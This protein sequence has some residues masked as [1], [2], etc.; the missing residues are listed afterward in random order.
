MEVQP[1]NWLFLSSLEAQYP[2]SAL[3]LL[4]EYRK[5]QKVYEDI[6]FPF[7][8][9]DSLLTIG[10]KAH[11]ES[12]FPDIIN[13][14]SKSQADAGLP[15]SAVVIRKEIPNRLAINYANKD[16][17]NLDV[18]LASIDIVLK[19]NPKW[20]ERLFTIAD[21]N[22]PGV[23]CVWL[24]V[25]GA[26]TKFVLDGSL[27]KLGDSFLLPM[28]A[29]NDQLWL[30]LLFKAL[31]KV[32]GKCYGRLTDIGQS[33]DRHGEFLRNLL[34]I[35][36]EPIH[37]RDPPQEILKILSQ[38]LSAPGSIVVAFE[39]GTAIPVLITRVNVQE[40]SISYRKTTFADNNIGETG[41]AETT[42]QMASFVVNHDRILAGVV[43]S[44]TYQLA[45]TK[46]NSKNN[47]NAAYRVRVSVD[48]ALTVSVSQP[49]FIQQEIGYFGSI[50]C[51]VARET[52]IN[53]DYVAGIYTV[54]EK[55]ARVSLH[56]I[57]G[58]YL[59][60]VD[61][62]RK[63][64]INEVEVEN[65][66]FTVSLS[67]DVKPEQFQRVCDIEVNQALR[68][69]LKSYIL[70]QPFPED[71]ALKSN[72][73]GPTYFHSLFIHGYALALFANES[74]DNQQVDFV[75]DPVQLDVLEFL[76]V[77][78]IESNAFKT[79][80]RPGGSQFLAVRAKLKANAP[81]N[82][83]VVNRQRTTD[84]AA[85]GTEEKDCF[86]DPRIF[87]E[88]A[89]AELVYDEGSVET[90]I[91]KRYIYRNG[92]LH[93]RRWKNHD[94]PIFVYTLSDASGLYILYE[95]KSD[96]LILDEKVE[97]TVKNLR[98]VNLRAQLLVSKVSSGTITQ[99]IHLEPGKSTLM[100][101]EAVGNQGFS[102]TIS[103]FVR[104][105]SK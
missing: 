98:L 95:N 61:L 91:L 94:T 36:F 35:E 24:C 58:S 22:T 17:L 15:D 92:A 18:A 25:D 13:S 87:S 64:K 50:R 73:D 57:P 86:S 20:L 101:F 80:V 100:F 48:T 38:R 27:P 2:L 96:S 93:Q 79:V 83:I 44:G 84:A 49:L 11:A 60:L 30:P 56:L 68:G 52:P 45:S 70:R 74:K 43:E 51:I 46:P 66:A 59:I 69:A 103:N 34:G 53:L 76:S 41:T 26:W 8:Y 62:D 71:A 77:G 29:S 7:S 32:H 47:R 14:S 42:G 12:R 9:P 19:R 105:L 97:L 39:K 37:T 4:S 85:L 75:P 40:G 67:A 55:T 89:G 23:Y 81:N 16:K 5:A 28:A 33:F 31:A 82:I 99:H 54:D 1:F 102:Y 65:N 6:E 72:E 104:I 10:Q 3:S 78:R 21:F 88:G 63:A 90:M